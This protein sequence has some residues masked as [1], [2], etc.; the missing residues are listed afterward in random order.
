MISS[1]P[2]SGHQALLSDEHKQAVTIAAQL[3]A[4]KE[5]REIE[6]VAAALL[7]VMEVTNSTVT[8]LSAIMQDEIAITGWPTIEN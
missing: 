2:H 6:R 4:S 7:N 1:S 5:N 8:F 3:T